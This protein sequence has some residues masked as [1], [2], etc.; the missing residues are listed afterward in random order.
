[1]ILPNTPSSSP[2][3]VM[4]RFLTVCALFAV[5]LSVPAAAAR[6]SHTNQAG[7]SVSFRILGQCVVTHADA[8]PAVQCPT[9]E[10]A[11]IAIDAASGAWQVYF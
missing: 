9:G 6:F 2:F 5:P 4:R 3:I 10:T 1:M 11:R 7:M 8:K